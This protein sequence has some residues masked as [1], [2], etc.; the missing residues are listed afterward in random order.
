VRDERRVALGRVAPIT[1][2][3]EHMPEHV[4]VPRLLEQAMAIDPR[5]G[6]VLSWGSGS[7]SERRRDD[8][9]AVP[10]HQ[11][12]GPPAFRFAPDSLLE[13][14]GFEPSVPHKKQPFL[15]A[16][17]R[18]RNSPSATKIGSFVPGTDG[19]N[20]SPSTGEL[21]AN[22]ISSWRLSHIGGPCC[23]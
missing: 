23:L 3:A 22:L 16:P 2:S 15:A 17:V 5:Y 7:L 18:S 13:G 14:D 8:D 10:A 11:R 20:P 9:I 19:S 6:L 21:V 1:G 12:D 4:A